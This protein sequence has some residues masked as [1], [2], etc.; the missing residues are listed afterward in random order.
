MQNCE[1]SCVDYHLFLSVSIPVSVPQ[2]ASHLL[3]VVHLLENSFSS[4][5]G[6]RKNGTFMSYLI[7]HQPAVYGTVFVKYY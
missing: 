4:A 5:E 1:V 3:H 6:Q 2:P 7:P